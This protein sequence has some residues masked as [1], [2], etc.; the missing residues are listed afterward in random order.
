MSQDRRRLEAIPLAWA[1]LTDIQKDAV[2]SVSGWLLDALDAIPH[3]YTAADTRRSRH[4][5]PT[6]A[7][8]R[9]RRSQ[10]AFI[11]GDRGTGKSSVLLTLMELTTAGE[12]PGTLPESVE[13]LH[14]QRDRVVWPEVLDMEPLSQGTNL[15]AAILARI[16]QLLISRV[17]DTPPLAAV[18]RNQDGYADTATK[19]QQLQNDAA[20]VWERMDYGSHGGD[21]QARALWVMQA[22]KAGLEMHRRFGEVV[23]GVARTLQTRKSEPPL[24][25]VLP[26]DDFDLAPAHCLQLLRLI[27]MVTTPGLFFLV[28]ANTRIAEFVLKLK[29]EGELMKLAGSKASDTKDVFDHATEIAANNMRK[30]VPP[31]QQVRLER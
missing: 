23:D 17:E 22:E 31:G 13:A 14:Q 30:L 25:F 18:L 21:P 8:D 26:V 16:D 9:K 11:D 3:T 27:R 5:I 4:G 10:L 29:S 1:S 12:F 15:F 7:L 24:L 19:L 20:I 2:E 6:P 28:A